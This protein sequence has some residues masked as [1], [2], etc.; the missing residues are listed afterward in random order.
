MIGGESQKQI[1]T[2]PY[3]MRRSSKSLFCSLRKVREFPIRETGMCWK[4]NRSAWTHLV[5]PGRVLISHVD[6]AKIW[7]QIGSL[8]SKGESMMMEVMRAM[9]ESTSSCEFGAEFARI[10]DTDIRLG[11]VVLC[12]KGRVDEPPP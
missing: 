8:D 12:A 1:P 10:F 5:I 2:F 6:I 7:G 9:H 4:W 11:S 3:F